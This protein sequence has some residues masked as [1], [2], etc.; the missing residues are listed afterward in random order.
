M[1]YLA[2]VRNMIHWIQAQR[3]QRMLVR[4]SSCL[5]E[6]NLLPECWK[7]GRVGRMKCMGSDRQKSS[8]RCFVCGHEIV[9]G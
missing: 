3:V 8:G 7:A 4:A 6:G 2:F 9:A 5:N 1:T